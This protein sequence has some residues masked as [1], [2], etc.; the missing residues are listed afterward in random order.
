MGSYLN[1]VSA[2]SIIYDVSHCP[3]T[4]IL[5]YRFYLE[6]RSTSTSLIFEGRRWAV[7]IASPWVLFTHFLLSLLL[8]LITKQRAQ[9]EKQNMFTV[10]LHDDHVWPCRIM[11]AFLHLEWTWV[12]GLK[13]ATQKL[14]FCLSCFMWQNLSSIF[15]AKNRRIESSR[16]TSTLENLKRWRTS[17]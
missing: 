14:E 12:R 13:L 16:V 7:A 10:L 6:N 1:L 8:L 5:S 3:W 9:H 17:M 15:C 11:H 4:W 2:L